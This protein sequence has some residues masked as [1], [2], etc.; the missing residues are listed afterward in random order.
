MDVKNII[1]NFE[2]VQN[3]QNNKLNHLKKYFA[4]EEKLWVEFE[5]IDDTFFLNDKAISFLCD[6]LQLVDQKDRLALNDL[7]DIKHIYKL[8]VEY[9]PDNIQYQEDLIAF[10]YNVMDD[11]AETLLLI[12]KAEQR[13]EST[14][15]YLEEIRSEIKSK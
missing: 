8:L 12:D 2:Q 15:K 9:Y 14:R 11:E 7:Q 1:K 6:S 3:D 4:D 5:K 10:V 13:S